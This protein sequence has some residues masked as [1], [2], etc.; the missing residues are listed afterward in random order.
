MRYLKEFEHTYHKES[1]LQTGSKIFSWLKKVINDGKSNY[2][3][4]L[5]QNLLVSLDSFFLADDEYVKALKFATAESPKKSKKE[6]YQF[7]FRYEKYFGLFN[8]P[9][10]EKYRE[11]W[12]NKQRAIWW[13]CH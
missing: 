5:L 9:K 4:N 10:K 1:V 8:N 2:H 13:D 6:S 3:T 12:N 7:R 11:T